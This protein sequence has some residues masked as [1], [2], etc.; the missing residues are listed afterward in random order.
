MKMTLLG[1]TT[2]NKNRDPRRPKPKCP[3]RIAFLQTSTLAFC[4]TGTV[5]AQTCAANDNKAQKKTLQ[6]RSRTSSALYVEKTIFGV[7]LCQ[8]RPFN[9]S[10][11]PKGL[12]TNRISCGELKKIRAVST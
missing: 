7:F 2:K 6:K 1:V 11:S 5:R 3:T 8:I 10:F 9:P 4:D 12:V